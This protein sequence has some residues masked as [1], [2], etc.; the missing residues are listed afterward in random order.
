MASHIP[1]PRRGA[2]SPAAH[3]GHGSDPA[4]RA[5]DV[6]DTGGRRSILVIDDDPDLRLL[7]SA[8]LKSEGYDVLTAENGAAGLSVLRTMVPDL[9][10]LDFMMPVMNGWQFREAQAAIPQYAHVPIVCLSGY[11]AARRQAAALGM[12]ACIQKPFEIEDLIKIVHR[13]CPQ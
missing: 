7:L 4:A 3:T 5:L 1:E 11:H 13:S 2:G 12:G 8:V 9:I 6:R 10:I